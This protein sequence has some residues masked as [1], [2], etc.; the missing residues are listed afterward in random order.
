MKRIG[1]FMFSGAFF[2]LIGC[3]RITVA[4]NCPDALEVGES[5]QLRANQQNPG[6]IATYAWSVNP[7]QAGTFGS[8]ESPNTTF[9]AAQNG[10]A[11]IRL[12]ASDGL[13]LA[14]AECRVQIG[15]AGTGVQVSVSPASGPPDTQFTLTCISTS[16][17]PA[18]MFTIDQLDGPPVTL[19]TVSAGV[20]RFTPT[21]TGDFVFRCV[22]TS[23]GG[24][25]TDPDVITVN[26]SRTG[27]GRPPR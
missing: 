15:P 1:V 7:T 24:V 27:G 23:S 20:V 18:T 5:V 22:G 16:S 4:P 6:E 9:M 13:F 8:A 3:I 14:T 11:V 2:C 25:Q 10:Q 17:P 26:V 12:S 19:T 21:S